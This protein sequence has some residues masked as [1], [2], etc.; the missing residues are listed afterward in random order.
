MIGEYLHTLPLSVEVCEAIIGNAPGSDA[1]AEMVEQSADQLLRE[2]FADLESENPPVGVLPVMTAHEIKM[3]LKTQ[4]LQPHEV[5]NHLELPSL[6]Y[7]LGAR[8]IS[9]DRKNPK[10]PNPVNS[11]R[12]WRLARTW[13]DRGLNTASKI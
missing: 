7:R 11:K 8:P 5:P 12:L 6:I 9:P 1:K 10:R 4:E 2:L 3:W 13:R